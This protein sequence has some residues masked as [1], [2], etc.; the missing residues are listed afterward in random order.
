MEI[1]ILNIPEIII[2]M[3]EMEIVFMILHEKNSGID[4]LNKS[5]LFCVSVI[6]SNRIALQSAIFNAFLRSVT[7]LMEVS[8]STIF[9]PIFAA[10]Q[11]ETC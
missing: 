5:R 10:A 9:S 1:D 2:E 11:S 6:G 8:M 3:D 7:V 4:F